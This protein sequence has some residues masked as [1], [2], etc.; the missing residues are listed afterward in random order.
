MKVKN[1]L[2]RSIII[3]LAFLTG[4][5]GRKIL[6]KLLNSKISFSDPFLNTIY[7]YAWWI[8][9]MILVIGLLYGQKNILREL[10]LKQS[11]LKGLLHATIMV[12]PML[13]GY[14]FTGSLVSNLSFKS[15]LH[16]AL[17]AGL[18]EELFFRGFL[19]G[20]LFR[21]MKWGFIPA[22]IINA[23]IFALGHIYQGNNMAEIIGVFLIT[24]FGAAW[25]AWLYIE[26]NENLWVP[27][28]L[29]TLMNLS[30]I[31]F[32]VSNNAIGSVSANIFRLATIAL[33][34]IITIIYKKKTTGLNINKKNLIINKL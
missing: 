25:F 13:L 20:Q 32:D 2:Y 16:G 27:I 22:V 10:G 23:I 8:I 31:I 5:Y 21:K 33:S 4:M 26:W 1:N 15:I 3:V 14:F 30:W 19:F 9:P 7:F 28:F 6:D 11:I 12:S 29:H 34:I 24:L 17:F 18:F